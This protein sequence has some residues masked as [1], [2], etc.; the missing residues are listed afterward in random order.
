MGIRI[1]EMEEATSFGADDIVPIVRS[2]SNKKITGSKLKD[3]FANFFVRKTGDTFPADNVSFDNTGTGL[4]SSDVE[5]AIKELATP[6]AITNFVANDT[7]V[8]NPVF[9][10]VIQFGKLVV[11]SFAS[12][13]KS[14]VV[15]TKLITNI[16]LSIN[17]GY[18]NNNYF[19]ALTGAN[20]SSLRIRVSGTELILDV[21]N[22]TQQWYSG[23]IAYFAR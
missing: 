16:P 1:S 4:T 21:A 19:G 6:T 10:K 13:I 3:F 12:E 22:P 20:G 15:N 18:T 14:A 2:N 8:L 9:I 23:L 17:M 11:V 7:Y 5:G